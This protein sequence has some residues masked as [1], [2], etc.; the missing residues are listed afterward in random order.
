MNINNQEK[1]LNLAEFYLQEFVAPKAVLIDREAA[2]LYEAL[3][4]LA[5]RG[6]L[7]LRVPPENLGGMEVR[8]N[9]FPCFQEMTA[10][11]SGA[12]A[13]L[14]TQHQG[15]T[16]MLANSENESLKQEY[17]PY[18]ASGSRLIGVGFSQLRRVGEALVKAV[19]VSGGYQLNGFI[20]WITGFGFF[21]EFIVAANLEDGSSVFGMIPFENSCLERGGSICFSEPMQLAAMAST[22]TVSAELKDWFLPTEKVLFI[23]PPNWIHEVDKKNVLSHSFFAL[24]CARAGLDIIEKVGEVKQIPFIFEAFNSLDKELIQCRSEIFQNP[25]ENP[26][27]L[28][29]WAIELASRCALAAV[30]VSSGAANWQNHP[31][32]MV[33]REVLVFT[34]SGQT[35]AVMEATLSRLV[36]SET[37]FIRCNS[38]V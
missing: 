11:Y 7:A 28:R 2:A 8:Q 3:Q 16:G 26:L 17:L 20:P 38:D 35:K 31:A 32:Q 30:T 29:A 14:Q 18:L 13:F 9:S 4:G 19:P 1:L 24:G 6:L 33:Y 25:S 12:L 34:V 27:Q 15:A 23:K 5:E 22:N 36:K 21:Q 10:R 37:C